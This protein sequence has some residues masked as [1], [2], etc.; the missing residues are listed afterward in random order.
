MPVH[1]DPQAIIIKAGVNPGG[2]VNAYATQRVAEHMDKY[3]PYRSGGLAYDTR[4]IETDKIIY[5]AP[6]AHYMYVGEV[7]GPSIPIK[8]NGV[9]VGF[10]SK[11][12]EKKQYTGREIE[13]T[14]SAG[15][16]YAGPYWEKRM[17]SAE[18]NDVI[19]EIQDFVNRGGQ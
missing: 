6:Y 11:K 1:L 18:K 8:E 13:Y 3:I 2:K 14:K 9:L 12:G 4:T 16:E 19:R 10:F 5:K 7:M 17:W 15:H